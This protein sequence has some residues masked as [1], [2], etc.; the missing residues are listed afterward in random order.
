MTAMT[1]SSVAKVVL[2]MLLML[3]NT[4]VYIKDIMKQTG[5]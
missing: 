2:R 1:R 5:L 4:V 3:H